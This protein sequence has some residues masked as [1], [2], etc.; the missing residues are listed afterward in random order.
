MIRVLVVDD[1][2][3]A[4]EAHAS[5]VSRMDGFEVGAIAHTA[6]EAR[7]A[8]TGGRHGQFD[9]VLLD[10]TLPDGSG[11]DVARRLRADGDAVDIMAITAVRDLDAVQAAVA[12]GAVSYLIKPFGFPALR[13]RLERYAD[14]R[15][16]VGRADS[17]ASQDEVDAMIAALRPT[18]SV[19][20]PKGLSASTLDAVAGVL[21]GAATAMSASEVA[22]GARTSRVTARR[23]LEHL[24][25][26]GMASRSSRYGTPGRPETAY[27]WASTTSR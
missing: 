5:Y 15:G 3:L 12:V 6:A 18:A 9:L 14:F 4:A 10:L 11:L 7:A 17:A 1:D 13:E 20:L 25:D 26:L 16:R 21:R 22:H 19:A 27:A 23:Y 24:A 8:L 2:Q